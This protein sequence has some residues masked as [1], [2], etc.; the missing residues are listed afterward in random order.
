VFGKFPKYHKK[1]L[2]GHFKAKVGKED[3]L[4]QTI[5]NE[6]LH[7]ISYDMALD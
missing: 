2:L 1:M 3:I 4:D 7:K 5:E 6:C